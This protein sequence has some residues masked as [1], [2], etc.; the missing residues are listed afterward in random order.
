MVTQAPSALSMPASV[1]IPS[2]RRS[3]APSADLPRG[4]SVARSPV[5]SPVPMP[6]NTSKAPPPASTQTK[7]AARL[8]MAETMVIYSGALQMLTEE[9]RVSPT[10]DDV[11][12]VAESFGGHIASRTNTSVTVKVPSTHFREAMTKMEPLGWVT[13]R[14]VS[15]SDVTEQFQDAEVR[16]Q[17]LRATRQR[18]QEFLNRA[19]NIADT[20]T[21]ERE[22]ERVA[23]EIDVLQGKLHYLKDRTSWSQVTVTAHPKPVV[24]IVKEPPPPPPPPPL[25]P[26]PRRLLDIPVGWFGEL[27]LPTLLDLK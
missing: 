17:N 9:D 10:L 18:L 26:A 23:Q 22:L 12:Q 2:M 6:T 24:A 3:E 14:S 27:G 4:S 21:V 11:V 5:S 13:D 7:P 1:S 19:G 15:A 25:P 16:L 20:L 8:P